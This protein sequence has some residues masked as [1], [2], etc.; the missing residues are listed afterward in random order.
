MT[1]DYRTQTADLHQLASEIVALWVAN[2]GGYDSASATAKLLNGYM[3]NPAGQGLAAVL[4]AGTDT[5][6]SGV[7]CL[8]PRVFHLGDRQL[9]AAGIADFAVSIDHRTLGPALMLMRKVAALGCE[10]FDLVYG[11]PNAKA[12]AVCSRAG[13]V[14]VGESLRY[15]KL[16][17]VGDRLD[18]HTPR[19]LRGFVQSVANAALRLGDMGRFLVMRPALRCL[20]TR[21]DDP[22]INTIWSNRPDGILLSERTSRMLAWRFGSGVTDGWKIC[23]AVD[24]RGQACGYVV[25]R[26]QGDVA[27]VGDFFCSHDLN[28]T[29]PLMLAFAA[30]ARRCRLASLSVEFFGAPEVVRQLQRVGLARRGDERK[31]YRVPVPMGRPTTMPELEAPQCWYCTR[32]END[33]D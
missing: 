32:F 7:Q 15:A 4:Y 18:G 6:I 19:L 27:E 26:M 2:L 31:I 13:L 11:L 14:K 3:N 24:A 23:K 16:L 17:R 22:A 20:P 10:R 33:A 21:W 5:A 29:G 9:H 8:H 1:A 25:W 12:A 30:F 28:G